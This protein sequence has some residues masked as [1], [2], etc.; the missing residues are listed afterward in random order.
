MRRITETLKNFDASSTDA[1]DNPKSIPA[2][3]E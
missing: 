1:S 3:L 2:R